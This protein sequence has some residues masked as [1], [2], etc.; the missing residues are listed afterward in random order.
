[1][2][3]YNAMFSDVA[4]LKYRLST[5]DMI[6]RQIPNSSAKETAATPAIN[7]TRPSI[8]LAQQLQDLAVAKEAYLANSQILSS[9]DG[10]LDRLYEIQSERLIHTV[11]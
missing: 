1:M 6:L 4:K 11:A 2:N 10:L 5:I 8:D 3:M 7:T 9:A